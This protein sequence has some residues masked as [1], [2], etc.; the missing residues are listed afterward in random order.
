M[1]QQS[2]RFGAALDLPQRSVLARLHHQQDHR[3][4]HRVR[5][6]SYVGTWFKLAV[7]MPNTWPETLVL[8]NMFFVFSCWI[9]HG[10]QCL[11]VINHNYPRLTMP[12]A[13]EP[14]CFHQ[15]LPMGYNVCKLH[16][17]LPLPNQWRIYTFTCINQ[18]LSNYRSTIINWFL[19][20]GIKDC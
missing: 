20:K 15:P 7:E 9:Y 18:L 3:L 6:D 14:C 2:L 5:T 12:H 17:G 19:S 4:Y 13:Y 10:C 11:T 16:V 1:P 8:G